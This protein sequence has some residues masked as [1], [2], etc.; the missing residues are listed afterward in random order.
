MRYS[1][2]AVRRGILAAICAGS[3]SA[4]CATAPMSAEDILSLEK[5][6]FGAMIRQDIAELSRYLASDLIY[7]HSYGKCE[8]KSEFLE[9][10]RSGS[11]RYEQINVLEQKATKIE[12]NLYVTNG[13]TFNV[14][15]INGI[16]SQTR[17]YY[18]SVYILRDGQWLL[19]SW[20]SSRPQ[21]RPGQSPSPAANPPR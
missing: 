13:L 18:T 4:G 16:P 12:S 2:S 19:F 11:V 5:Q 1:T 17:L 10:V 21:P 3:V 9:T 8:T 20:Q 15:P 6:R 7:C 14:G